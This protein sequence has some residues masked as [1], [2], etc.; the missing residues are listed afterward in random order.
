MDWARVWVFFSDER[1]V[2]LDHEDSNYK[3]CTSALLNQ[4]RV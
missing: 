4:V 3:A 1:C 2:P